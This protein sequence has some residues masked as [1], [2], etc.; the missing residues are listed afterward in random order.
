MDLLSGIIAIVGGVGGASGLFTLLTI[1]QK[2]DS[3]SIENMSNALEE[4]R[5]NH[6]E[7]KEESKEKI[8]A[9]EGRIN[10][11][12]L[13]DELQTK[14]ISKGYRCAL[15]RACDNPDAKCPVVEE[16]ERELKAIEGITPSNN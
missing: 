2:R 16:L 10:R 14:A 12:Y 6:E 15:L 1:R 8:K 7:F 11:L 5:K 3:L 4:F 9:L 13:K